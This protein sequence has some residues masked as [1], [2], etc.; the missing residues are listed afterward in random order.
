MARERKS[1]IV[2]FDGDAVVDFEDVKSRGDRK[3]VFN[4]LQKP[5]SSR[6]CGSIPASWTSSVGR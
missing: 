3:A 5:S 2:E 6:R 4:V 1:W